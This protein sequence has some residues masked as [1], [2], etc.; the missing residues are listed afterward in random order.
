MWT[1][2]L[3]IRPTD[4][5]SGSFCV[6]VCVNVEE[7]LIVNAVLVLTLVKYACNSALSVFLPPPSICRKNTTQILIN[8]GS[9]C[10]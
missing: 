4:S 2:V 7:Y 5:L 6:D 8:A 1:D 9:E 3:S 10:Q